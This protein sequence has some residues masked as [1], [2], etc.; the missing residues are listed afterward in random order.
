MGLISDL[1]EL[2]WEEVTTVLTENEG[3]FHKLVLID[4]KNESGWRLVFYS[5]D[6][7][8]IT[9]D[10]YGYSLEV[11]NV[12]DHVN[13]HTMPPQQRMMAALWNKGVEALLYPETE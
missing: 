1:L 6:H 3:V 8:G 12:E 11:R 4:N 13:Y 9:L 2:R 5:G 7:I 10:K